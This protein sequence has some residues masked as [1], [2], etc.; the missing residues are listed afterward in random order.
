MKLTDTD[1]AIIIFLVIVSA[2]IATAFF[3]PV[4]VDFS[5]IGNYL[6]AIGAG[7]SVASLMM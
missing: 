2:I 3:A 7:A 4:D 5:L 6:M 1:I